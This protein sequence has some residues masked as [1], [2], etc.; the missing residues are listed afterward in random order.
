MTKAEAKRC[1]YKLIALEIR[2]LRDYSSPLCKERIM[3][4]ETLSSLDADRVTAALDSL[5]D[6]LSRR[7]GEG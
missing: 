1:A 5:V 4:D 6:E 2:A 3:E 7:D